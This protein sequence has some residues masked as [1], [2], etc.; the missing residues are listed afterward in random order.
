MADRFRYE[1][2]D[3]RGRW[4]LVLLSASKLDF[5][6]IWNVKQLGLVRRARVVEHEL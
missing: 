6:P 5:G 2:E 4:S 1:A 3:T